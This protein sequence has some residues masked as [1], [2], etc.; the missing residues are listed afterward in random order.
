[1]V[2]QTENSMAHRL[3][4]HSETNRSVKDEEDT[5]VRE[6]SKEKDVDHFGW[7]SH[8]KTTKT[9]AYVIQKF[10]SRLCFPNSPLLVLP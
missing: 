8:D 9:L 10:H 1:M 6:Y 2:F 7:S 3:G 4:F 5:P